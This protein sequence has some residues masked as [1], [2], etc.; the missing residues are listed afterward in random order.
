MKVAVF[1]TAKYDFESLSR[2]IPADFAIEFTFLDPLLDEK[3]A[4]LAAGHD[5]VCIFVN[6]LCT[7]AVVERLHAL[8]VKF[9]ALRCAGYNNVDL[10]AAARRGLVVAR[11]PAYS[12]EAVAE[13]TVGMIMTVVRKYHKAYNRVREGNFLLDGLLGMNIAGKTVGI[14]GTGRI[15]LLTGKI[16]ALGFGAVVIAYDPYPTPA[17]AAHGVTYVDTVEELFRRADIISLHCPL[18]TDTEYI[19]NDNSLALTKKGVILINTSRGGL[20][21]TYALIRAL[22]SGH[23]SAVGLDVYERESGYFFA[24]SS[25][26]VIAD[27]SF[28]RLLSFYN[29]FMTGHQAFLTKEALDNIAATTVNNLRN[30]SLTGTTDAQFLV[31][32]SNK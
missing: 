28:A 5:A 19:I 29:V 27:D 6:D 3:T 31:G 25:T 21:D 17:A 8:G 15:G 12:P 16:L 1:G 13:F 11:V 10:T 22:K 26:K 20:I 7:A 30:M 2:A 32:P 24:D 14:I 4:V 9:I 18:T 23:V